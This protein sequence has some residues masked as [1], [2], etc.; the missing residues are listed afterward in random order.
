VVHEQNNGSEHEP[1]TETLDP[2]EESWMWPSFDSIRR[3][4]A[5]R[6]RGRSSVR[7]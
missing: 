7:F 2:N 6:R 5:A 4:R 3:K 1:Q